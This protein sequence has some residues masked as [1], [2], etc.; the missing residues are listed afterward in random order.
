MGQELSKVLKD[1]KKRFDPKQVKKDF[2]LY[3]S[4]GDDDDQKWTIW[5]TAKKCDIKPGKAVEKA[6]CVLKTDEEMFVKMVT[7]NYTPTMMEFV[8][9]KV[10]TND[11][12]LLKQFRAI[13]AGDG[14]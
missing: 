3:L 6:D 13:F 1:F 12:D 2:T 11:V 9:G 5:V 8:G 10:K 4:L 14:K 7:T